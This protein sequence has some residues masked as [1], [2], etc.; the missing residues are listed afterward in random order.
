M[1][2]EN[3]WEVEKYGREPD[4]ANENE[5][6]MCPAAVYIYAVGY[7]AVKKKAVYAGH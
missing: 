1:L 5:L 4:G 7:M 3:C 6:G 2:K